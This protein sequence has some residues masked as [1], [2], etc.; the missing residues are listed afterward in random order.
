M[1]TIDNLI[2]DNIGTAIVLLFVAAL[3]LESG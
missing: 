1:E 2:A 3:V